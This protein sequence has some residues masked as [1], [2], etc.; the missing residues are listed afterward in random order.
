MTHKLNVL[1]GKADIKEAQLL[2]SKRMRKRCDRSEEIDLGFQGG[3]LPATVHWNSEFDLWMAFHAV[4]KRFWNAFGTGNPFEGG[5]RSIVVEINFPFNGINRRIGGVF[6]RDGK[7]RV[8]LGHRG[9]VGGGRRGIGQA[10]FLERV[11]PQDLADISDGDRISK[12]IL[13]SA[14]AAED[15]VG[16]V[17]IFV[18]SVEKFK[19]VAVR[20][21]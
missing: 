1:T 4:E 9:R 5:S 19:S 2:L 12:A 11:G 7:E 15:I 10:A 17:A 18:R 13:I 21:G 16:R 14:I 8:F 6:L 3:G 20:H